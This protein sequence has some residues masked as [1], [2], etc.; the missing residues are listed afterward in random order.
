MS[1]WPFRTAQLHDWVAQMRA[2]DRQAAD[3][4]VRVVLQRVEALARRML[5]Q[6]PAARRWADTDDVLQGTLIR[7]LRSLKQ[8]EPEST[9]HFLNLAALLIRHELID[10]SRHFSERTRLDAAGA[11]DAAVSD[12]AGSGELELDAWAAFHQ[13]VEQ[14]PADEREVVGLTYYHGWTQPEIA[15]LFGVN[16]RTVRRRWQTACAKLEAA[17]SGKLPALGD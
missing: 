17:L 15:E 13:A 4:L 1:D 3:A 11:E 6:Y 12:S 14:L 2:G 9:R 10:L 5:R 8:A 7:L 16:E